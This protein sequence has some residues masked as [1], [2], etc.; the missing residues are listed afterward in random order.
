MIRTKE[1]LTQALNGG[2]RLHGRMG[3]RPSAPWK[4][5]VDGVTVHG[6]A[7]WAAEKAGLLACVVRHWSHA[8]YKSKI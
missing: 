3:T 1:Q 4:Y 5:E 7:F 8:S 6:N 2:K